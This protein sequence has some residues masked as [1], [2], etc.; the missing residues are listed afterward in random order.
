MS[1]WVVGAVSYVV[2]LSKVRVEVEGKLRGLPN[3]PPLLPFLLAVRS[4]WPLF[5]LAW[6]GLPLF[7]L[8]GPCLLLPWG[9]PTRTHLLLLALVHSCTRSLASAFVRAGLA[10][11]CSCPRSRLPASCTVI[12]IRLHTSH[13]LRSALAC[14]HMS[15]LVSI[16]VVV[17][18]THTHIVSIY[19]IKCVAY[20]VMYLALLLLA[21]TANIIVSIEVTYNNLLYMCCGM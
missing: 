15:H 11:P 7:V 18:V 12:H 21:T 16:A 13:L 20:L 8:A 17:A 4:C 5:V 3:T 6:P 19:L 1:P 2:D 10:R 14:L 9:F